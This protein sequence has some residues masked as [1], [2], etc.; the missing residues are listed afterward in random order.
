[1]EDKEA[2]SEICDQD[3]VPDA[4]ADG[5]EDGKFQYSVVQDVDVA[6]VGENETDDIC[7][8]GTPGDKLTRS[9]KKQE[10]QEKGHEQ[11][12]EKE[13]AAATIDATSSDL[14]QSHS[15]GVSSSVEDEEAPASQDGKD[16]KG[17][18][19]IGDLAAAVSGHWRLA[20]VQFE[21]TALRVRKSYQH[22]DLNIYIVTGKLY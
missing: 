16:D 12:H 20:E 10:Q 1:M 3:V 17:I 8:A 19:L 4:V 7:S 6:V 22:T 15:G 18:V 9:E 5:Q 2:I 11:K 21:E 14:G 13:Q